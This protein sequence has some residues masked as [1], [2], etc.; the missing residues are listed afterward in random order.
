MLR[1][2]VWHIQHCNWSFTVQH[3]G[4]LHWV[5]PIFQVAMGLWRWHFLTAPANSGLW[6]EGHSSSLPDG[7]HSWTDR[8]CSRGL[9]SPSAETSL[10][11]PVLRNKVPG[12]VLKEDLG[13]VP[14]RF[15]LFGTLWYVRCIPRAD[16]QAQREG[17]HQEMCLEWMFETGR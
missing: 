5:P 7:S 1:G 4:T 3:T 14:K 10:R 13:L 8:R 17:D 16:N 11:S 15:L 9:P 12:R 2:G 6:T